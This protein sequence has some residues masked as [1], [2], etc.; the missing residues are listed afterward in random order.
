MRWTLERLSPRAVYPGSQQTVRIKVTT[1]PRGTSGQTYD[2]P[3]TSTAWGALTPISTEPTAE[4]HVAASWWTPAA[5][6]ILGRWWELRFPIRSLPVGEYTIWIG[7]QLPGMSGP[8]TVPVSTM[9]L[10]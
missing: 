3:T 7:V 2:D 6:V 1:L 8:Q 10:A 4:D 9:R 5:P